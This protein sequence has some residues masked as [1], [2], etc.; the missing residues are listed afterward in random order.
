MIDTPQ[1]VTPI[2]NKQKNFPA[3]QKPFPLTL[4]HEHILNQLNRL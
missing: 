1:E 2:I 3:D 4:T